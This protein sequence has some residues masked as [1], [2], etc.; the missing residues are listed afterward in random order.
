MQWF[1]ESWG[2]T[3]CDPQ[4]HVATP[5]DSKCSECGVELRE[6]DQ[7]IRVPFMRPKGESG[8]AFVDWHIRCWLDHIRPHDSNCPRCRGKQDRSDHKMS[9]GYSKHGGNCEC[10][11]TWEPDDTETENDG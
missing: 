6:G 10:Y 7:G 1:G 9:C 3:I 4:H 2:A 5:V 8:P 11:P